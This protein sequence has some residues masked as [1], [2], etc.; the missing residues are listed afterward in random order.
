[1]IKTI[2]KT[3]SMNLENADFIVWYKAK[4]PEIKGSTLLNLMLK[5]GKEALIKERNL[6]YIPIERTEKP[7]VNG[8]NI[9]VENRTDTL[10]N[11]EM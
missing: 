3:I 4:F 9:I 11:N 10:A 2:V 5:K 7:L 1:M 8:D 6:E